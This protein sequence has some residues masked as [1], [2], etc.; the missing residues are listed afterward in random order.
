MENVHYQVAE[1]EISYKPKFRAV[2]RP[3][4]GSSSEAYDIILNSWNDNQIELLEEFKIVLLNRKNRV[5][6]IV[7][8]SAG[9]IAG[10]V[11][12]AKIVFAIALKACAS[13]IILT[14]N[15]PSGECNPSEA[16]IKLTKNLFECGKILG[17]SVL[18]HLVICPDHYYSFKDEGLL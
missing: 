13:G 3:Q 9:G 1:I 5:L 7:K 16:D 4:I 2:D 8:I 15:H 11:V 17:I 14:H 18:D 10:T 6:G 12:D